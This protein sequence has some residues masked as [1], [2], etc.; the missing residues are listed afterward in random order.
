MPAGP[1]DLHLRHSTG[2]PAGGGCPVRDAPS[3]GIENSSPWISESPQEVVRA[4]GLQSYDSHSHHCPRRS[5]WRTACSPASA[6]WHVRSWSP[7]TN[8]RAALYRAA[9]AIQRAARAAARGPGCAGALTLCRAAL[10]CWAYRCGC[11]DAHFADL[12]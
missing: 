3:H 5:P 12:R 1:T 8:V 11:A 7:M 4:A 9:D 6:S 10:R 2:L